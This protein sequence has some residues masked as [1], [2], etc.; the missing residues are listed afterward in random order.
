M[1]LRIRTERWKIFKKTLDREKIRLFARFVI[2][3]ILQL[4]LFTRLASKTNPGKC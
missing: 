2:D 1:W 3:K 4:R